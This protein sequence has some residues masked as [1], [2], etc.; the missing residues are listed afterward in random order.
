MKLTRRRLLETSALTPAALTAATG[1]ALTASS[2]SSLYAGLGVK[3]VINGVGVV[4]VLGGSIMPPEVVRAMEEASRYFVPLP[5]LEK[6]VGARIAE[7]LQAPAAMVTCGAASAIAVGT[8]ACLSQGDPAKL[9]QLPNRDGIRF[10]VIQQ[11]SHRSGYEH[12]MELCGAKIVTVETRKE[13]EAAI[14]ERTGM[15]FFLNKADPNGE[16]K[17]A[18]FVRIGKDRGIPTMN[19]AASDA[20]P[21]ENLWKY[22][23]L[24]FDLVIFSGGKALRGPQSSGLLL[25]RKD[26]IEASY[27]AMSPFGGIGRG[28]KV[29]KE[30]LCGLLAA[31]ERYLK[32][33]HQAEYRQLEDRVASIRSALK[34]IAGVE[35]GRHV[36]VIANEVPHVTVQWDESAKGLSSQQ[37]SEKL[38]AGDPPI[39][40]QRPG[41]GQLLISVWMMRGDEHKTVGRRLKEILSTRA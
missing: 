31:V 38:L 34:G 9:R 5:E 37:V 40:V 28:M 18:D 36:P 10:E 4:T 35:T 30:E 27:P 41:A 21:K 3:P 2:P 7:L 32:V 13:L 15:M 20:T 29:G 8:A 11:K 39:H 23:K 12:Q 26:L 14:N 22:T 6:K 17:A 33:D 24:G 16:I 25:G 1:S 19:D